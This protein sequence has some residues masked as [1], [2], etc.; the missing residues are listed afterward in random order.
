MQ[1]ARGGQA[2]VDNLSAQGWANIRALSQTNAQQ[3]S[4]NTPRFSL[5]Q[6]EEVLEL[7]TN[8]LIPEIQHLENLV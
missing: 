4:E 7:V 6:A 1:I 2:T 8:S 3:I 5:A